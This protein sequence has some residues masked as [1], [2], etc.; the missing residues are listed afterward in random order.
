MVLPETIDKTWKLA[1]RSP[2]GPFEIVDIV[3]LETTYNIKLMNPDAKDPNSRNYKIVQKL[4]EM[5]DNG[6]LGV[7][8]GE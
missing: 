1:T 8:S 5:I 3:G 7:S 4:K 6:K 2:F